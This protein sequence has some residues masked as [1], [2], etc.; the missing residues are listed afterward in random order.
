MESLTNFTAFSNPEFGEIRTAEIDGEPWFV[1]KDVADALGYQNTSK[2]LQDH[3]DEEDKLNNESLSS[4]GQ[5]GGWLIT[6][7]G[8]YALVFSSKLPTA[9]KFKHWVTSE[10][11]PSIRKHGAYM[12][13]ETLHKML[14]SPEGVEQLLLELKSEQ[15][16]NKA[17]AADNES[18]KPAKVFADAVT[19]S[20]TSILIGD[21]AK[22][23]KG[24][25]IDIGQKRL[26]AWMRDNGYLIHGNNA[27]RN[28]PTQYAMDRGL[29]E[30]KESS[31]IDGSG[32]SH[33]TRTTKVTGKGQV[34]FVNKFLG[35]EK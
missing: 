19:T 14:S 12:T 11:L 27:S 29:F 3:V 32:T 1:G 4:L 23:L 31:F 9:K 25:G 16:K 15:E 2:A 26:F 5:R 20:K 22:V 7:S 24:N 6:E 30:V 13:P 28:M 18:M 34:Y 10:V 35:A 8:V 21:L 33:I 17:L